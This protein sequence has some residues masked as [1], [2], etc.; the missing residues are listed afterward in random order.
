MTSR[1]IDVLDLSGQAD[2]VGLPIFFLF[3][4]RFSRSLLAW[5]VVAVCL[6]AV[7][8]AAAAEFRG[9]WVVRHSLKSEAS[10]RKVVETAA[11]VGANAL[12]V[13][14]RGRGDAYYVSDLVP[15][16]EEL[17]AA[18]FDPLETVIEE[19]R[20]KGLS[21]HAWFNVYLT[22]TPTSRPPLSDAH[23]LNRNPSWF[24]VSGDGIQMGSTDLGDV[25][26]IG[27]GVEGRYLSPAL[28]EVRRHLV[29]VIEE[30]LDRYPIE[31][32]H[33][34]YVRYPN[35]HYDY[36]PAVMAVFA[37]EFGFNPLRLY[38]GRAA[39][40]VR[41]P[42][43]KDHPVRTWERWRAD[44]VTHLVESIRGAIRRTRPDV[45]LSAAV[46]PDFVSAYESNGQDWIRWMNSGILD[47]VM[48]MFY[49]GDIG[50]QMRE[51]RKYV[52]KGSLYAGLG[53]WNQGNAE[54]LAQ[55]DLARTE[56]LKGIVLYSYDTLLKNPTLVSLLREESFGR[57]KGRGGDGE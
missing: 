2:R 50:R 25:D 51:A 4:I 15:R 3:P 32:I 26:L 41:G 38:T 45:M 47:A 31:G 53:I 29:E 37:Q 55:V 39:A 17:P 44:K 1:R 40:G 33:L 16:A 36:N 52:K 56:R 7:G 35:R 10:I 12:L 23:L 14:I 27:R 11:E 34:D 46:K 57:P 6:L 20:Q 5:L 9:V 28:P 24:M 18:P 49:T 22:W 13:Q 54:T 43:G 21:V 19:A 30:L 42:L 8:E 48:P